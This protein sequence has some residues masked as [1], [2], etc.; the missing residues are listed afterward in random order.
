MLELVAPRC[1]SAP[2][3]AAVA[4][5]SPWV[6]VAALIEASVAEWAFSASFW[7][8]WAVP[9]R[10][11]QAGTDEAIVFDPGRRA[12][13][14][15]EP[16]VAE[17]AQ[18]CEL[19][20]DLA[21]A[22]WQIVWSGFRPVLHHHAALGLTSGLDEPVPAFRRRCLRLLM[23]PGGPGVGE[24]TAAAMAQVAAQIES[25][26][27]TA[28]ELQVRCCRVGVGWYPAGVTPSRPDSDL[29]VSGAARPYGTIRQD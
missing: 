5:Y 19:G 8:H 27:L 18:A 23:P 24:Q 28:T 14:P 15:G 11:G 1:L 25:R 9:V 22:L 26:P 6:E 13:Y 12:G 4:P 10:A 21:C 3:G 2:A 20:L 16:T 29:L 17:R 7:W